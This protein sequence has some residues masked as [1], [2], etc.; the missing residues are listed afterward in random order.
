MLYKD[1]KP[2]D[3]P[4]AYRPICLLDELGKLLERVL[5]GRIS[6]HLSGVGP[7]LH[8]NQYGFRKQR[9]TV[10]AIQAVKNFTEAAMGGGNVLVAV[11]L[12]ISNAFNSLPWQRIREVLLHHRLPGYIRRIL[13]S[14]LSDRWLC[15]RN[16]EG[17][18][19][20]LEVTRGVP[21]GSVLG[22][23]LWDIGYNRVLSDV[24]LPPGCTTICYADDTLV[25]AAGGDW[26]EAQSRA[27]DAVSGVVRAIRAL[28][29]EVAPV[30]TEAIWIHDGARGRRGGPPP[31]ATIRMGDVAV[32]IGKSMRYL[33]LTIDS[34][35]S[36]DDHF[37][38][39]A[40]RL[41]TAANQMSRLLPNLGGPCGRVR[42]L[43]ATVLNSM[44]L[45]G[46]PLWSSR[47]ACSSKIRSKLRSAHRRILIR[48][49]RAY[50]TISYVGATVLT[51]LAPLELV[52]GRHAE[53]YNKTKLMR[54]R[55]GR[56][57]SARVSAHIKKQAEQRM[58]QN[59][60]R[61]LDEQGPEGGGQRIVQAIQPRLADWTQRKWGEL[62]FRLTQVMSGHGC[63]SAYLHRI[64]R[65]ESAI[66]QHCGA[67]DDTAQHT[68]EEC[69]AWTQ[70]RAELSSV[71]GW[72][73]S[74][75]ACVSSMLT[76]K[77]QW[78]AM[79]R[80]CEQVMAQKEAAERVRRGEGPREGRHGAR[81]RWRR[82]P[83]PRDQGRLAH[84]R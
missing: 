80:F 16:K 11:S 19:R 21:Q 58:M 4:S 55:L 81:G 67:A 71:V 15:Y 75:E 10:D 74:L 50:R 46:A 44:A 51:G 36:F 38:G 2:K 8:A 57:L 30:K 13:D 68:L 34:R 84:I 52:A 63:F 40:P 6:G 5:A 64:G 78:N 82:P 17:A 1:G 14:Y 76:S 49:A 12:D 31:R 54:T 25:L 3:S 24:V 77:E 69:P 33:G 32:P 41:V 61:W 35:W 59:W 26:E 47:I 37:A 62:S 22:P 79:V 42:K 29:L 39:L 83:R 23:L 45:Y 7:D 65:D 18:T 28:S 20:R 53:V 60:N 27:N 48:V 56:E 9:S 70:L 43:Y 72:D 66:C 73:L